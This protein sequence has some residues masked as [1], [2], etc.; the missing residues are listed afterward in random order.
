MSVN[1]F[2]EN[3]IAG[4]A[5]SRSASGPRAAPA[6]PDSAVFARLKRLSRVQRI[7]RVLLVASGLI[8]AGVCLF[9]DSAWRNLALVHDLIQAVG[10][11][12]ILTGALGRIWSS[13]YLNGRKNTEL[14]THGPYSL[15]RNPLYVFSILGV[16]GMGLLSGSLLTGLI[17]GGLIYLVFNW[18]IAQEEETL[19]MIFGEPYRHYKRY[20]PRLGVTLR[21]WNNPENLD[22]STRA[23]GRTVREALCFLL[24]GPF[25]ILLN[26]LHKD[27]ILPVIGHLF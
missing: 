6:S 23:L 25:F 11:V 16:T 7:R 19:E 9:T 22:I 4:A 5:D 20:V 2:T 15:T 12:L 10:L 24:A 21:H 13:L 18:V 26:Y 8:I 3:T 14:M 27:G 1:E 17:S